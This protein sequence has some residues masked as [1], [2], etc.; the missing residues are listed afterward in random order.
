MLMEATNV[1]P[2]ALRYIPW[3]VPAPWKLVMMKDLVLKV[4]DVC[5]VITQVNSWKKKIIAL[6]VHFWSLLFISTFFLFFVA[7]QSHSRIAASKSVNV[8]QKPETKK[9]KISNSTITTARTQIKR[10]QPTQNG[11]CQTFMTYAL[12]L[13]LV[14]LPLVV[15]SFIYL[16][17]HS[18]RYVSMPL[19][20]KK[21]TRQ[22]KLAQTCC[23]ELR[24]A[25][26]RD[27]LCALRE[28][29]GKGV[30]YKVILLIF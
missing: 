10:K 11:T 16:Q 24:R 3:K 27:R 30:G 1:T 23:L 25:S 13:Y 26:Q 4:V 28:T 8:A 29:Q 6:V 7:V 19:A 12:T 20:L 18:L 14:F 17:L 9:N 2:V 21:R 5:S 15:M 22:M